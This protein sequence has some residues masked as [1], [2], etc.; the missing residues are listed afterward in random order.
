MALPYITGGGAQGPA[1]GLE[2][3]EEKANKGAANGYAPLDATAK[4][5]VANLP[6]A[7]AL[8][9]EVDAKITTHN[10]S[11]AVHGIADTANLVLTDDSRL[12]NSRTPTSHTHAISDVTS[13]QS[14]I[15]AFA[16]ALG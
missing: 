14:T 15:I 12:S 6:D 1:S 11:T 3:K 7:T 2:S 13:L 4:V 10:S 9:E 5:P 16:I 8:D